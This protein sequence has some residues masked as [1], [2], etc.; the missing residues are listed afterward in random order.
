MVPKVDTIDASAVDTGLIGHAYYGD[1]RSI[2]SDMFEVMQTGSP[3][4]KR[5]GMRSAT[6][7]EMTYWVLN[8]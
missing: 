3:P 1:K 5:F 2:L 4:D 8:P 7:Q 6:L